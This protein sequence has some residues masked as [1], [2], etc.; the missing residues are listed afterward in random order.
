MIPRGAL[1]WTLLVVSVV[2]GLVAFVLTRVS[3]GVDV[4]ATTTVETTVV[5]TTTTEPYVPIF[6]TV[7]RGD[8][9]SKIAGTYNVDAQA[10]LDLNGIADPNKLYAGQ[11]IELP[12]PTGYKPLAPSTTME[13]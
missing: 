1:Q 12:P 9:V 3:D 6:Y 13:P 8:T 11:T 10:L 2:S 5:V 4:A 7:Q